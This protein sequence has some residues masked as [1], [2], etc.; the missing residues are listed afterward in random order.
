MPSHSPSAHCPYPR[1]IRQHPCS[2]NQG[3]ALIITII[4]LAFLVLLMVSMASL[5]RVETQIAANCQQ[6]AAA[7]ENALLALKL[8]LGKLQ[9][10]AGPDQRITATADVLAATTHASKNKWTGVWNSTTGAAVGWLVSDPTPDPNTPSPTLSSTKNYD[11]STGYVRLIGAGSTDLTV[12]N[13]ITGNEIVLSKQPLKAAGIPGQGSGSTTIGNYAWWIGDE[14]VKAR[15][16]L[17]APTAAR[18]NTTKGSPAAAAVAPT[19]AQK[20]QALMVPGRVGGELLATDAVPPASNPNFIGDTIYPASV[21][22]PNPATATTAN[23]LR[24]LTKLLSETQ[25]ELLGTGFTS[26]IRKRRF[27]DFTVTSRGVLA[28]VSAGGLKKDL[29]AGLLNSTLPANAPANATPLITVPT[30]K[31]A[32]TKLPSWGALRSYVQ[33][34]NGISGNAPSISA[35]RPSDTAM[36]VS[37]VVIQSQMWFH[38]SVESDKS[39]NL[40]MFPA[41][42]LWNPYD[43]TIKAQTYAGRF[44]FTAPPAQVYADFNTT[45]A[46][47]MSWKWGQSQMAKVINTQFG[48]GSR[49]L[50]INCPD[51]L[52]GK[53]YVFTPST[54][55]NYLTATNLAPLTLN[56]GWR[57]NFWYEKIATTQR[58]DTSTPPILIADEST[59]TTTTTVPAANDTPRSVKL[60]TYGTADFSIFVDPT[61]RSSSPY[62]PT[63]GTSQ[64]ISSSTLGSYVRAS[65]PAPLTSNF[66]IPLSGCRSFEVLPIAAMPAGNT[67]FT[68]SPAFGNIMSL[69]MSNSNAADPGKG[70]AWLA[71]YNPAAQSIHRSVLDGGATNGYTSGYGS[72]ANYNSSGFST[73]SSAFTILTANAAGNEAYVGYDH[74]TGPTQT[75]L[76]HLPRR[77]TGVLSLGALQHVNLH[78]KLSD[79]YATWALDQVG[80]CAGAMPTYAIGNSYADPRVDPAEPTGFMK[81]IPTTQSNYTIVVSWTYIITITHFDLSLLLNR[82][83]WD[84]YFFSGVP[85]ATQLGGANLSDDPTMTT[86]YSANLRHKLYDPNNQG[87]SAKTAALQDYDKAAA[88]LLV[89]GAFNINSTSR[90]AWR[91]VL[92]SARNAPV[93][94]QDGTTA[95]VASNQSTPFPRSPYPIK[96]IDGTTLTANNNADV[97]VGFRSLTDSQIDELAT[98]I[99]AQIKLRAADSSYGPFRSLADFINRRPTASTQAYQ[100][101]GLLQDAIDSTS[102]N[103][104]TTTGLN[105]P[106]NLSNLLA[107]PSTMAP[108]ANSLANQKTIGS[109]PCSAGL[110][111]FVTQAD[112]LQQLGPILSARSDT[113]RIRTYGEVVNPATTSTVSRA[114]CEAIVQRVPDYVDSSGA[115]T[116][117][118]IPAVGS[119]NDKF[120]RRFKIV[121]FRWL[122]PSDL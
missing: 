39:L 61:L 119:T 98:A 101:K 12:A 2:G 7:R 53:A 23:F 11:D 70:L 91:A 89:D 57:T 20:R 77:E 69:K 97:Y 115:N 114:W 102:I 54:N 10:A 13:P 4:L 18:P 110:P 46:G 21:A 78:P 42:V 85:T 111:G 26:D 86:Y 108:Y 73:S 34:Q 83:I 103:G 99:V 35:T 90:E 52:P 6:A 120:G 17:A 30:G 33:M 25:V 76:F 100:L 56:L 117:E 87:L 62:D 19:D 38:A 82:V 43:V 31:N 75:I 28:D 37:P 95:S 122:G 60:S 50:V 94:Q 67:L 27:H 66:Y 84:K 22:S 49:G 48:Y 58:Y 113:F 5:T 109:I 9:A 14:G 1:P 79:L 72:S 71:Q 74:T 41:I 29:T 65:N 45:T 3:F 32:P 81:A 8:A 93:V 64:K 47:K 107:E 59:A 104:S 40:L 112:L 68:G 92:A 36:S 51:L 121:S 80:Y 55:Q 63:G 24:D 15:I 118:T 88:N 106:A 44:Y 116:P 16:N 105:I 96:N